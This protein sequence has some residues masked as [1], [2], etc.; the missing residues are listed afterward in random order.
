VIRRPIKSIHFIEFS[1][2]GS[3]SSMHAQDQTLYVT[4][5]FWEGIWG[6][7]WKLV[8]AT[9][10]HL[11][12]L[13]HWAGIWET[14]EKLIS[15]RTHLRIIW[16]TFFLYSCCVLFLLVMQLLGSGCLYH[17]RAQANWARSVHL[18]ETSKLKANI[19]ASQKLET[20]KT[21]AVIEDKDKLV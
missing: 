15:L 21:T 12:G 4:I 8:A 5:F 1:L 14:S 16:E 10:R 7:C 3:S 11:R 18:E 13:S 19:C 6:T 2:W 9:E 17:R 20:F